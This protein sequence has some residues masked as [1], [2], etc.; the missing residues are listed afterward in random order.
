MGGT[1]DM[2]MMRY[3][4]LFNKITGVLTRFCFKY[5]D[6]LVFCVPRRDLPR[7]LGRDVSNVKRLSQMLRKR[8]K[9]VVAPTGIE[10]AQKFIESIVNPVQFKEMHVTDDEIT[11]NAG[12]MQVKAALLGRN[13]VR[14]AEMQEIVKD[15]FQREFRVL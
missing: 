3:L 13:K 4:N 12:G 14:L 11:I 9:I 5:N 2:Q 1:I 7:A 6:G 8:I 15:Y 10:D